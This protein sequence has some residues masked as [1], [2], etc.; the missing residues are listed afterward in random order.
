MPK[1]AN[2][3]TGFLLKD[4]EPDD[5]IAA[6]RSV[7]AGQGTLADAITKRV[8]RE[9]VNRRQTPPVTTGRAAHHS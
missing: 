4:A 3:T 5:V 8:L 2:K 6:V 1:L 7:A 9:L